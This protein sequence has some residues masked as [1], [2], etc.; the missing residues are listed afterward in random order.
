MRSTLPPE[1]ISASTCRE[2]SA[3]TWRPWRGN[4]TLKA[5]CPRAS[6]RKTAASARLVRAMP[7][8]LRKAVTARAVAASKEPR[9][10]TT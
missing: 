7:V 9:R 10:P 4:R 5:P 6:R 3:S 8:T 2:T 1:P